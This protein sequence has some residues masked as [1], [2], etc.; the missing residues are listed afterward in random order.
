MSVS[1][2]ATTRL[3]GD[4]WAPLTNLGE[5]TFRTDEIDTTSLPNGMTFVYLR[6][7]D[8]AGN[9]SG[10]FAP[11]FTVENNVS[12]VL[13]MDEV[14]WFGSLTV[15]GPGIFGEGA[16][17]TGFPEPEIIYSWFVCDADFH[18]TN[19]PGQFYTP[20]AAELGHTVRLVVRATS[21]DG[22][23]GSVESN[24][25]VGT[26]LAAPVYAPADPPADPPVVTQIPPATTTPPVVTTP[27]KKP[28]VIAVEKKI[29][30]G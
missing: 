22:F 1:S 3:D 19:H 12:P 20:T 6:V 7:Y 10:S 26:V 14:E 4:E 23:N 15:D 21:W 5:G 28:E 16:T 11:G 29:D 30:V 2:P 9:E 13:D 25:V 8:A 17:A 27:V 18:C 24:I